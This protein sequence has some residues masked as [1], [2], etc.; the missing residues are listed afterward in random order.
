M[1]KTVWI[2]V[3]M[4]V[5]GLTAGAAGPGEDQIKDAEK[6]W[7]A[8][9]IAGDQAA[10]GKILSD[11]IIYGHA[12]GAVDTKKSYLDKLKGG[13]QKYEVVEWSDMTVKNVSNDTALVHGHIRM[14]GKTAGQ[15]FDNKNMMLLHVWVKQGGR[16]Q[17]AAH[18]TAVVS[19][20]Q[21]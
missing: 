11:Q 19:P 5:A 4:L 7:G 21:H 2:T 6:A 1:R 12:S 20:P 17:L 16:W 13:S 9:L 10:L 14:G 15:P 8:A 18:Q 3:L